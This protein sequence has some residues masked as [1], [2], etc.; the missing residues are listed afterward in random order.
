MHFYNNS[1]KHLKICLI[2]PLFFL[3]G[4]NHPFYVSVTNINF[5]ENEKSL[6]VYTKLFTDDFE[7]ALKNEFTKP[8][9][10]LMP[11]DK[12]V[13]DSLVAKYLRRHLQ[14]KVDDK[15][16]ILQFLGYEKDEEGVICYLE[17]TGI[18]KVNK[19]TVFNNLI[20]ETHEAQASIIRSTVKGKEKNTKMMNPVNQA[21][22]YY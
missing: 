9:N 17:A 1:Y 15:P 4:F 13:A 14:I 10:L 7:A 3:M 8:V 19:L 2:A 5:N 16:V 6:E 20:Y 12:L 21:V 11:A 18:S 22:L